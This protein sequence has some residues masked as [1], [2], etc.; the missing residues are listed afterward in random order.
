MATALDSF[1]PFLNQT[2]TNANWQSYLLMF[3]VD[4]VRQ[5]LNSTSSL[6]VVQRGAGANKSV[7]VSA[8]RILLQGDFGENSTTKNLTIA[9]N[10]SGNPRID[11]VVV[12]VTPATPTMELDILQGTPGAVP[13]A[14]TLTQLATVYEV[15][16]AQIAVANGFASIVTANITSERAWGSTHAIRPAA[17]ASAT[18]LPYPS[19]T[20]AA[21]MVILPVSGTTNITSIPIGPASTILILEFA[22][23]ACTVTSGSNLTMPRDY[24]STATGTLSFYSDG[25]NWVEF[26]RTRERQT[27]NIVYAGPASG[28]AATPTFRA[29]V[30]ADMPL[31]T[32]WTPSATGLVQGGAT[33]TFTTNF[34]RTVQHGKFAM[35][36]FHC[37]I[38]GAGSAANVILMTLPVSLT[39]AAYATFTSIGSFVYSDASVTGYSGSAVFNTAT[40]VGFQVSSQTGGVLLGNGPSFA[41]ANTDSLTFTISVELA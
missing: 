33:P 19:Y 21:P 4:G 39:M 15:S 5:T 23:A 11:R 16:L 7:D 27:A 38:T 13:V 31:F 37:T 30:A 2:L 29:M 1:Y 8:G 40:T 12:R 10:A 32:T 26:A 9:D 20:A 36:T 34:A 22:S 25:T 17:T 28:A 14:P 18:A 41:T 35:I 24:T 3:G 6:A